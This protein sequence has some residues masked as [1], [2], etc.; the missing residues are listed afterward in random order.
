MTR[1]N[2]GH[3]FTSTEHEDEFMKHSKTPDISLRK[4]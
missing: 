1:Q 4:V 2:H 3:S